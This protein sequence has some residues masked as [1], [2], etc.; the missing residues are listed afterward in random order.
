MSENTLKCVVFNSSNLRESTKLLLRRNFQ[1]VV[2]GS[3]DTVREP[4]EDVECGFIS[5]GFHYSSNFLKNF[6]RIRFVASNSTSLNHIDSEAFEERKVEVFS[7]ID[8]Q[9]FLNTITPTSELALA[10]ALILSRNIIP[11]TEA[12]RKRNW[13][14]N[15]FITRKMYSRM[16]VGVLGLG[17]LGTKF[18]EYSAAMGATVCY[19]DPSKSDPRFRKMDLEELLAEVDLISIHATPNANAPLY[20]DARLLGILKSSAILINTARSEFIDHSYLLDSLK[21]RRLGGAALD[22]VP[23][24]FGHQVEQSG[25]TRELFEFAQKDMRLI[26]TPH[27]GGSTED[28]RTETELQVAMKLIERVSQL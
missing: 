12:T 24:E 1:L 10:L 11:A 16:N 27:I 7:L 28:A 18:A 19:Y 14:R 15:Q 13:N 5:P 26:L 21:H 23:N 6:P 20:L 22:V 3:P 25:I 2:L 8:Q 4:D 17:R 9:A